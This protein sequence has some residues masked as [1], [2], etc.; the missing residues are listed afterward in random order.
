MIYVYTTGDGKPY[1]AEDGT[2]L[3][4]GTPPLQELIT[5]RVQADVDSIRSLTAAIKSGTATE[6][7]MSQYLNVLQKGAYTYIDLNRVEN[8]VQFI[9][10]RLKEYGYLTHLPVTQVWEVQDK[11]NEADFARYF[12]NVARLRNAVAVWNT[13]PEVPNS[14]KGFDVNKANA[15]EQVLVDLDLVLN[16]MADAWFYSGDL[17]SAEV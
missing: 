12:S 7:Q 15:L 5:D 3:V 9:A 4:V 8:A 17:Y 6:E 10:D 16:R 14:I 11:P 13:T 1:T 2:L